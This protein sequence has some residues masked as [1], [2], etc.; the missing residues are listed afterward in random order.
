MLK[1]ILRLALVCF[2]LLGTLE[3]S[4]RAGDG[5][6]PATKPGLGPMKTLLG[7]DGIDW[8]TFL[9]IQTA[10]AEASRRGVKLERCRI[11]AMD[12]GERLLVSFGNPD[13]THR[14]MGCAPGPCTCFDV[15]LAKKDLRV[16]GAHFSR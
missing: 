8:S 2:V 16:L 4:A 5:D 14:W 13:P 10:A 9:A 6:S 11:E 3:Y 7:P 15:K 12:S 1:T